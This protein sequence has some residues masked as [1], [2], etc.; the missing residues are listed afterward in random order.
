M[1][2]LMTPL[3]AMVLIILVS[4]FL[5]ELLIGEA[6]KKY[7][8]F[9]VS[10]FVF[11]F[12]LSGLLHTDVSLPDFPEEAVTTSGENLLLSRY[13]TDIETEV[14]R[15]LS[16]KNVSYESVTA[17]LSPTYEIETVRIQTK[18]TP[19]TIHTILKGAFPYEVAQPTAE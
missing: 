1:G 7:I 11:G 19:E 14:G 18:E 5:K 8:H 15:M 9:A 13:E 12:L 3:K 2:Q 6:Y 16:E 4:E 17:V 10:L